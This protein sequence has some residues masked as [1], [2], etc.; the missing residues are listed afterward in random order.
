MIKFWDPARQYRKYKTELDDAWFS[1]MNRGDLILREDVEKFEKNLA[2][3][4]GTKYAV[5]LSSGTDAIYLSLKALGIGQGDEVIT[6]AHTFK[7]TISAIIDT[8]AKPVLVDI[9]EDGLIDSDKIEEKISSKTK[10]I[11]PVHI[12]GAI[13]DM[14]KIEKI[15]EKYDIIIIED[16][17]QS[18]GTK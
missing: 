10:A 14:E 5:G 1:I 11:I 8:G 6:S 9:G 7:S 15:A 2:E 18:L 13:C 4:V 3:F 12:A 16:S 17:C